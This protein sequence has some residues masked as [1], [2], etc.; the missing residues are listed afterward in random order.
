MSALLAFCVYTAQ[1]KGGNTSCADAATAD[2]P[3]RMRRL[4][5]RSPV[6]AK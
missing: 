3:L 5:K 6:A 2:G 1:E 4:R